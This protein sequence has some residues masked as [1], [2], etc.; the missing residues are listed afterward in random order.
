VLR[1]ID[2]SLAGELKVFQPPYAS[3]VTAINAYAQTKFG[4]P[5]A[6]LAAAQQDSV[7]TDMETN[8]ATGFVPSSQAVFSMIR[9][10][11][12][13]GMFGD[14]AHGGNVGYVGWKLVRFPGP[15]LVILAH[16]QQLGVVPKNQLAS[17]YSQKLFQQTPVDK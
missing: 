13:Q 15:R 16:D 12:M 4:A 5:F 8:A 11:A 6:K 7:L 14:P 9:T 17:T 2:W 1:Y 3:A 10:H